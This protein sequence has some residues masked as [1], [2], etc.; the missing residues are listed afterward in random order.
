[1]KEIDKLVVEVGPHIN[2]GES[3][4]I[5]TTF[6]DNGDDTNNILL[7]TRIDLQSYGNSASLGL[8]ANPL[9]PEFLRDLANQIESKLNKLRK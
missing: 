7:N 5:N 4:L 2:G 1:M 9:T 3:V 6:F 8:C